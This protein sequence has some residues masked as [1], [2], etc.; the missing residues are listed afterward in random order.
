MQARHGKDNP[1]HWV[2]SAVLYFFARQAKTIGDTA[3][4]LKTKRPRTPPFL[5]AAIRR[6]RV[7]PRPLWGKGLPAV[8][9]F[10]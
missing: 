8:A 3:C 2:R 1:C 6:I 5:S 9:P 10:R 7:P 4:L